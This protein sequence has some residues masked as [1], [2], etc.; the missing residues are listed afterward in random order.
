MGT[1]FGDAPFRWFA[2]H[3]PL[4]EKIVREQLAEDGAHTDTGVKV[5][6]ASDLHFPASVIAPIWLIERHCH[7]IG[8][9]QWAIFDNFLMNDGFHGRVAGGVRMG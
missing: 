4:L 1:V 5:T 3:L 2:Q 6:P 8:K 7:I 9:A